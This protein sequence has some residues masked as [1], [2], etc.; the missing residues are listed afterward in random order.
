ML[1]HQTSFRCAQLQEYHLEVSVE[2][3]ATQQQFGT[4]L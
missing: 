4:G 1:K 2:N 3:N